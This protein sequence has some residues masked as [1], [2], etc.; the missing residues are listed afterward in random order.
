LRSGSPVA[1]QAPG[2]E[3][4]R[5]GWTSPVMTGGAIGAPRNGDA[6][7]SG[8]EPWHAVITPGR[9]VA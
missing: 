8:L 4:E 6:V 1:G 9:H 5:C 3:A 7:C 2:D